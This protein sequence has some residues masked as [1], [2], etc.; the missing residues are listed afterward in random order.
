[1]KR[2]TIA[3]S[4]LVSFLLTGCGTSEAAPAALQ[5]TQQTTV[6]AEPLVLT[7]SDWFTERD[8]SGEYDAASAVRIELAGGTAQVTGSGAEVSGSTVTISKTGVYI[9]S[10][11][12]T[13]GQVII[14]AEKSDKIQLVLDG[15]DIAS[16]TS[17][18]IYAKKADKV[19][20]TLAPGSEN[21]LKNGGEYIAIDDNA[22]DSVIFSKADLTLNGTGS[23]TVEAKA[24]HGIVSKDDLII[25]G[26]TYTVTAAE[27]GI[28]GKDT[29]AVAAGSVRITSTEDGLRA[30]NSDDASLGNC[31]IAGGD[32]VVESG[33]D[34]ISATGTLH[35]SGGSFRLT[36]GGGSKAVTM[37]TGDSMGGWFGG[38][39]QTEQTEEASAST[40][41]LKSDGNLTVT[42]GTFLL[43]T[44]DDAVHTGGDLRITGGEWTVSSGDDGFHA[45]GNVTIQNGSFTIS[46]CYEGIEGQNV[47]IDGGS[48]DIEAK[49]DGINAAGGMDGSGDFRAPGMAGNNA[50][51]I[52]GGTIQIVSDGDSLDSNGSITLNGGTLNLTCN[53]NGNTAVDCDGNYTNNGADITTNDGSENGGGFGMQGGKRGSFGGTAPEGFQRS[54]GQQ[55]PEGFQ[56][57]EGMPAGQGGKGRK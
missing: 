23:L 11:T 52:N 28:T 46:Y 9:L 1:M 16:Q 47:T 34:A 36:T 55:R 57:P 53:G 56:R 38:R 17:A 19:L 14:D 32:I 10:G 41:G 45:D 22:I 25:G 13:D 37:K 15:V 49:D 30:K 51:V 2:M 39:T 31:V 54:E 20:I 8:L 50:I 7:D 48:F 5:T 18:A 3:C 40:K 26:G 21:M 44:A 43:D 12:L 24:G 4:L 35:I 29:V 6:T 33:E 27:N 42:G